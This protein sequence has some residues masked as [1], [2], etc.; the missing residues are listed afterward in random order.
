MKTLMLALFGACIGLAAHAADTNVAWVGHSEGC[1]FR[2]ANLDGVVTEDLINCTTTWEYPNKS[3]ETTLDSRNMLRVYDL[4]MGMI[5][6]GA[7][8]RN[9]GTTTGGCRS[10][11]ELR[12][13]TDGLAAELVRRYEWLRQRMLTS[14]VDPRPQFDVFVEDARAFK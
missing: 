7:N 9:F 4:R 2:Y 1:S 14:E 11:E 8:Y 13:S 12:A 3:A 10:I 5:C 6:G